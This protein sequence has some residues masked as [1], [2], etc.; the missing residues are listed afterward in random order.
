MN[1][2]DIFKTL[3]SNG[4]LSYEEGKLLYETAQYTKGAIVE[5]GSY[6]GRSAV[7]L[8]TLGREVY[9]VDPW[10]DTFDDGLTG[11][12]IFERFLENT[13]DLPNI[14]PVRMR[15][16]DWEPFHCEFIYLDGDHTEAGTI[17]QINK[18]M[19]CYPKWIAMH[20]VNDTGQGAVIKRVAIN[21]LGS[22]VNRVERLAIWKMED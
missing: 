2:P 10:D 5:V 1:Y 4:W 20:D 8:G 22:W 16:E 6:F 12:F 11:Q 18:A 14:V 13:A 21:M 15:V 7:L 17:T 19:D 9:C 3:P